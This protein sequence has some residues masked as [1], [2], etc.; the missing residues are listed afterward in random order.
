MSSPAENLLK[1]AVQDQTLCCIYSFICTQSDLWGWATQWQ[2]LSH[3]KSI[4]G[5]KRKKNKTIQ[6]AFLLLP[7]NLVKT[8]MNILYILVTI[9]TYK[10]I[11]WYESDS[12]MENVMTDHFPIS[13]FKA[14]SWVNNSKS[15]L[16]DNYL[17]SSTAKITKLC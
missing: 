11:F 15:I 10:E 13:T 6:T 16:L 8:I 9:A 5:S 7:Q 1:F 2:Y 17:I 12:S 3:V 4:L 14:F